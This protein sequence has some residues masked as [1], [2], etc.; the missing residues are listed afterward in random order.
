MPNALTLWKKQRAMLEVPQVK[1]GGT[2]PVIKFIRVLAMDS[3]RRA[4]DEQ[5]RYLQLL[6]SKEK[7]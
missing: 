5:M 2:Y 3:D 4:Y 1:V 6:C 7:R